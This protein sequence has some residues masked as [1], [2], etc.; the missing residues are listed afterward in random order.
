MAKEGEASEGSSGRHSPA[1]ETQGRGWKRRRVDGGGGRLGHQAKAT[2]QGVSGDGTG[3]RGCGSTSRTSWRCRLAPGNNNAGETASQTTVVAGSAPRRRAAALHRRGRKWRRRRTA[4]G[5]AREGRGLALNRA[6][7]ATL[8]GAHA[9]E[10]Q[11]AAA[12][13]RVRHGHGDPGSR[14]GPAGPC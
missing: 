5:R 1:A 2:L 13:R 4:E 3:R 8:L 6:Q 11:A 9:K 10:S 12:A 7:D 14:L